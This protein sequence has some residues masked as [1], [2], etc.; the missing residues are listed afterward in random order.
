MGITFSCGDMYIDCGYGHFSCF[1]R[2][3]AE[4]ISSEFFNAYTEPFN[5]SF[6]FVK[7]KE[8]FYMDNAKK[9][10]SIAKKLKVPKRLVYFL[11]ECDCD[12]KCSPTQAKF[13]LRYADRFTE[14]ERNYMFG[15]VNRGNTFQTFIDMCKKSVNEKIFIKWK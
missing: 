10:L 13:I 9:V 7:D 11:W 3:L 2:L 1:R 12:G 14:K 4:K 15:F 5:C 6:V 8:K